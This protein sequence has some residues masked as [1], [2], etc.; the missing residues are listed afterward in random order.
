MSWR[1]SDHR[2][3]SVE[4]GRC[5]LT[6]ATITPLPSPIGSVAAPLTKILRAGARRLIKQGI[7]ADLAA[8]LV[9]IP[10]CKRRHRQSP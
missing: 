7:E 8:L 1:C 3:F 4:K 5:D 10:L 6:K 2:Q 9:A